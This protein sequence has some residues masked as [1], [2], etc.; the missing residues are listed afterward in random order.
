M[1]SF[2]DSLRDWKASICIIWIG[3]LPSIV[4]VT[5]G[6]DMGKVTITAGRPVKQRELYITDGE[7]GGW[8]A[9][10][11]KRHWVL[12]SQW[13]VFKHFNRLKKE[14]LWITFLPL[15]SD[16]FQ[17]AS[18]HPSHQSGPWATTG[19]LGPGSRVLCFRLK[20]KLGGKFTRVELD[21]KN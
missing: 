7:A 6:K 12:W 8:M 1:K 2:E 11:H 18:F 21:K 17:Q 16:L 3:K 20:P 15:S 14:N 5:T 19:G 4:I 10:S 9:Q 13:S